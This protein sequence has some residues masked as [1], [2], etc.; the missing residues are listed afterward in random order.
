MMKEQRISVMND[1]TWSN[2][3]LSIVLA[4]MSRA[5]DYSYEGCNMC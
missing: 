5:E 3:V 4:M 2:S 1:T